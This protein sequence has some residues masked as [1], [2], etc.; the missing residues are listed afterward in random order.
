M[1]KTKN[2]TPIEAMIMPI[3]FVMIKSFLFR[4]FDCI[5][6]SFGGRDANAIAAK[7]S[8]IR[9]TH[10]ICVTVSGGCSPKNAPKTTTRHATTF[11]II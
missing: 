11:T 7:V 3:G 5:T 6:L 8:I 4:G 10:N 9:F 2:N 1:R